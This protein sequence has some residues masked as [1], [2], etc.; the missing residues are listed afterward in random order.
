MISDGRQ[1]ACL[2]IILLLV[3]LATGLETN[4][5][6][7]SSALEFTLVLA[8]QLHCLPASIEV[9]D[10]LSELSQPGRADIFKVHGLLSDG[11]D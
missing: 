7:Q 10:Q 4:Q 11:L 8:K 9:L 1:H 6:N 3:L 5:P 2:L